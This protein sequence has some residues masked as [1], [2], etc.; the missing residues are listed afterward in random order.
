MGVLEVFVAIVFV[1]G[2]ECA[3]FKLVIDILDIYTPALCYVEVDACAEELFEKHGDVERVGVET[4][5]I[6]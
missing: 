4:C 3:A 5:Y 6:A 1:G 2:N